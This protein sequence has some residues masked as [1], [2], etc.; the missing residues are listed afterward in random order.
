M[1]R[2]HLKIGPIRINHVIQYIIMVAIIDYMTYIYKRFEYI[3]IM[4]C[5]IYTYNIIIQYFHTFTLFL[6]IVLA[7]P[8][9]CPELYS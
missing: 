7:A 6:K 2:L 9:V 8:S 4:L 3:E 5:T 1:A